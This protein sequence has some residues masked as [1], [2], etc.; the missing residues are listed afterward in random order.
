MSE[1]LNTLFESLLIITQNII[2]Y[3]GK[4]YKSRLNK[5]KYLLNKLIILKF[6]VAF[7]LHVK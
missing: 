2:N 5:A 6:L 1:N 7:Y 4:E 3:V